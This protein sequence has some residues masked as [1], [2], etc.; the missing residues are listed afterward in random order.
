VVEDVVLVEM[1]LAGKEAFCVVPATLEGD[2]VAAFCMLECARKAERKLPKKGLLVGILLDM[3]VRAVYM[4]V[5]GINSV[6]C[7]L[8]CLR[9]TGP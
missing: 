1:V 7:R 6:S 3:Q 2:V 8:L 5:N 9:G 4:S